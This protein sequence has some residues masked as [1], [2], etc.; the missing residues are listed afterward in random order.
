MLTQT[1][2]PW[3]RTVAYL[4]KRLHPVATGWPNCLR[5]AAATA[6]LVKEATK[7][8]LGQELIVTA[9]HAVE[10][11]PDKWITNARLTHH[12]TLLLDRQ[13]VKFTTATPLNPA[14]LLPDT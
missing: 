1:L 4:S 8:T 10:A 13:H 5:V 3:K 6:L 7:L 14:T 2:G 11:P 9:P 12:Q